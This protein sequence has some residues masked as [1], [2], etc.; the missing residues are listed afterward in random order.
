[1]DVIPT[2]RTSRRSAPRNSSTG[3]QHDGNPIGRLI[4][5]LI[6]E[7]KPADGFEDYQALKVAI[8]RRLSALK[9]RYSQAQLDDAVS[10]VDRATP[11]VKARPRPPRSVPAEPTGELVSP[12]H[13]KQILAEIEQRTG[14]RLRQIPSGHELTTE[15]LNDFKRR[16]V[17][18]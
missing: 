5:K 4:A 9:V 2:I 12:A 17:W 11:L 18:R 16:Y 7:E 10:L 13:A 3:F 6:R 14:L 15:A 1:M 8:R